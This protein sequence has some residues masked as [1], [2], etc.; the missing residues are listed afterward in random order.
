MAR[1]EHRVY[2]PHDGVECD[3]GYCPLL[4]KVTAL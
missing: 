4:R 2:H 3:K 1:T